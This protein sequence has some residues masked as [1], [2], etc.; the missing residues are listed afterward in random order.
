MSTLIFGII[1]FI[2]LLACELI[3]F[4]IASKFNIGDN[5][6]NRS[7]HK[8]YQITGG[9]IIFIISA[10]LFSIWHYVWQEAPPI[11]HFNT[12]L[13]CAI[14]LAII[15][16]ADDVKEL[17]PIIRLIVHLIVYKFHLYLF[18]EYIVQYY[19]YT[20]EFYQISLL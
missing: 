15:S 4:R 17:S 10:I 20:L 11:T 7:S 12:M 3:Y 8:S 6:T 5:V 18:F 9:G 1:V 19:Y 13:K 14:I 16:F 2:I